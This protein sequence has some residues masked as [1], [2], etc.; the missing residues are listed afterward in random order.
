M[1][2]IILF[3]ALTVIFLSAFSQSYNDDF[4]GTWV[5]EKMT[6]CLK[7]NCKK[8]ILPTQAQ[9]NPEK[10]LSAGIPYLLKE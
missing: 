9:E 10:P 8:D 7:L 4:V 5:Y 6:Q 1:K 3:T 2:R